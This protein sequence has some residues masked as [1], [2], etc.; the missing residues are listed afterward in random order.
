MGVNISAEKEAIVNLLMQL[1]K[2]IGVK[3]D[4]HK[5]KLLLKFLQK[6]GTPSTVSVVFDAKTWE[7]AGQ[8]IWEAARR[9]DTTATE[10]MTTWRLVTETLRLWQAEK[11][12]Q[13]A[14]TQAVQAGDS[15]PIA[16][17]PQEKDILI[18][19]GEKD[20]GSG[21]ASGEVVLKSPPLNSPPSK[22]M[23]PPPHPIHASEAQPT[24]IAEQ[25]FDPRDQWER[26]RREALK[27]G[28][29]AGF[30][31]PVRVQDNRLNE[32][33]PFQ[34]DLIKELRKTV[35][36][37]GLNAPFT[38]S[39]LE[40]VMTGHLLTPY[41]SRQVA[42][43]I[44]TPTQRL[45][46]KQKWK[47]SCEVAALSNLGRQ[48]GDPLARAG[49]P[50]LMGTDPL[51]D[52]RLQARLDPNILRQS[53]ALALQAMLRLPEVGKP[54]Q[55]FTSIR[56]GLQEPYMQFIDRLR[57]ALDK[58]IENPEAKEALVL[59]LAVENANTDCKKLL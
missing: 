23:L 36:V 24:A 35:T 15:E 7:Q 39:L 19:L 32:W 48:A 27:D 17:K 2:R 16:S 26:F 1:L 42:A 56:Q 12:V 51:L 45:L 52:P 20:G 58:Q 8:Q 4:S 6:Q 54:E 41:D 14:V 30:V 47:E 3:Y 34:W 37:Y 22:P 31:F 49:N 57:D 11:K 10:V 46:W 53:A 9:G 44:L 33:T 5:I 50:Q 38:E 59:K 55:S 28:E 13:N 43:M 21:E 18:D 40:N 25:A 29:D